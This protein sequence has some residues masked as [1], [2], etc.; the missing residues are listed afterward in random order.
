M[1]LAGNHFLGWRWICITAASSGATSHLQVEFGRE[2]FR[3]YS[4]LGYRVFAIIRRDG[5]CAFNRTELDPWW[6]A[7]EP[8]LLVT[9]AA[10]AMV[11]SLM[12]SWAVLATMYCVPVRL[13][14]FFENRD[15]N[16]GQSWRL[17]GAALMP[18]A[19]FLTAGIIAYGFGW[20]D[21]IRL[22][23]M[24]GLHFI[25]GWIYLFITPYF[26]PRKT[27]AKKVGENPFA[28]AAEENKQP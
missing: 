19:L 6:G 7:W 16:W 4:L 1:Q 18:G 2:D 27:T 10:L 8:W 26:C 11:A 13:I 3:V 24:F 23:G 12:V 15:L 20:M 5:G 9:A 14:T 22:G 28:K 25:V 21:L 17:A